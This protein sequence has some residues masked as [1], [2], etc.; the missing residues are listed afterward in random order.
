MSYTKGT[1]NTGE[2]IRDHKLACSIINLHGT[3]DSVFDQSCLDE[4]KRFTDDISMQN[5]DEILTEKGWVDPPGGRP[6]H[7]A[8]EKDGSLTGHLIA[9]YGTLEPAFDDRD[10]QLLKEF[11]DRGM[12]TG[13]KVQR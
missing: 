13:Q 2:Q 8:V 6:G 3:V 9:R 1:W 4:L 11:L 10:W 5:R 7:M 12:P